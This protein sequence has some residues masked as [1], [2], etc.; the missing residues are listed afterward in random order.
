MDKKSVQ[1]EILKSNE[2][3]AR[4]KEAMR[5]YKVIDSITA[6]GCDAEVKRIKGKLKVQTVKKSEA[7]F[8]D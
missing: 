2:E 1:G 8:L 5:L 3:Q 7:I 4:I 6:K